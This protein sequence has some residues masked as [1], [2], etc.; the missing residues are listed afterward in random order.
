ML[1]HVDKINKA[2]KA[3]FLLRFLG[4]DFHLVIAH[5]YG[6]D[7]RKVENKQNKN[8]QYEVRNNKG[9]YTK[10]NYMKRILH[11]IVSL[12]KFTIKWSLIGGMFFLLG[13]CSKSLVKGNEI[14]V[15]PEKNANE[16]IEQLIDRETERVKN[17]KA[18]QDFWLK[19]METDAR[20]EAVQYISDKINTESKETVQAID[21][22]NNENNIEK[23]KAQPAS[24]S[25]SK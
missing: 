18:F 8:M 10:I 25:T 9:R 19:R 17:T 5:N 6:V 12:F 15:E 13:Y 22:I 16:I 14:R 3:L 11:G 24:A 1:S 4:L 2:R 20:A 21:E 23:I 7:E